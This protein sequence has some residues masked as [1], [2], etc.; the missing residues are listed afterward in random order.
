MV[1]LSFFKM[2]NLTLYTTFWLPLLTLHISTH[3]IYGISTMRISIS[4][5]KVP[6]TFDR[7]YMETEKFSQTDIQSNFKSR[8]VL[9]LTSIWVSSHCLFVL[10][11]N[12]TEVLLL[13]L[14]PANPNPEF[15]LKI[16]FPVLPIQNLLFLILPL[17]LV[18]LLWETFLFCSKS[19]LFEDKFNLWE[20]ITRRPSTTGIFCAFPFSWRRL[21][22]K[23]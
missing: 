14:T 16:K 17:K 19:M 13:F 10:G 6:N 12:L 22:K 20:Y 9:S 15:P 4:R 18:F 2:T 8:A 7:E 1:V 23:W 11:Q 5:T 21:L 3:S